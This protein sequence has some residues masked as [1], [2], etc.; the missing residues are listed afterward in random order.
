MTNQP[1]FLYAK[2]FAETAGIPV[3][4]ITRLL[5]DKAIKGEKE[6]GKWAIPESELSAPAIKEFSSGQ[7]VSKTDI[8]HPAPAASYSIAEFAQMTYLTGKGV[9]Q[10]L[11]TGRLAGHQDNAG[12]WRVDASNC[13]IDDIKRLLR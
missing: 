1:R 6:G 13:G 5:R 11:K 8:S 2:E 4:T 9:A 10:W 12:K 3:K 7:T